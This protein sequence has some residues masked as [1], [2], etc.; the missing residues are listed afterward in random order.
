MLNIVVGFLDSRHFLHSESQI[1][2]IFVKLHA[3][4]STI[5]VL[6]SSILN[7]SSEIL[8]FSSG[9]RT[10]VS[11]SLGFSSEGNASWA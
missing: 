10:Y 11:S 6:G 5:Q 2:D 9:I 7:L 8:G 1:L 3:P 4:I